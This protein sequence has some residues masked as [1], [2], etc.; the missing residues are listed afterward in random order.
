MGYFPMGME[1]TIKAVGLTAILFAGPLFEAGIAEG[2]WH[3]WI[4]LRGVQDVISGWRGW[5]DFVAV[6]ILSTVCR[7]TNVLF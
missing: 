3:D 6:S 5:R 7:L 4:R 2:R 1:E